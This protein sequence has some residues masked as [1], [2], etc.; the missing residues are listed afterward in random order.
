MNGIVCEFNPFHNGHKYLL[1]KAKEN[2]KKNICVMSGNF[3][4]RGEIA[5]FDKYSRAEM[6]LKNGADVIIDLP[7]GWSMSGAEN[8]ALGAVSLLKNTGI[9]DNI[10]FGCEND[11]KQL[12]CSLRDLLLSEEVYNN[13]KERSLS[14]ETY[15]AVREKVVEEISPQCAQI[16]SNPNSTLGLQYMIA[17][18][19]LDFNVD[20]SPILRIGAVHDSNV[21]DNEFSSASNLRSHF[22]NG[23]SGDIIGFFPR[24]IVDKVQTL[25]YSNPD[26]IEKAIL[27]KLRSLSI[28]D[29]SMLPDISEGIENR[30]YEKIRTASS[31]EEL[32]MSIKTK[33]YTLA[34]IRRIIMCAAFGVNNS[35]LKKEVP[36]IHIIGYNKECENLVSAISKNSNIPVIISGKDA[37]KLEGFAKEVFVTESRAS[38]LYGLSFSSI[39]KCGREYTQ[40]IIKI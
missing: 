15:A 12:Y 6:A 11:N 40:P 13:I 25:P 5:L 8:F 37:K 33:R 32:L 39:Q 38:D 34:R 3:V 30:I 29:I 24:N 2:G 28:S 20:F 7:I 18:K 16:L 23:N 36:Y 21:T 35:F 26:L 4:Q 19:Q 1:S 17:A 22:Y 10:V 27:F 31:L 14:G 9:V